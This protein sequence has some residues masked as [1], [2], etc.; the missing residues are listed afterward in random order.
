MRLAAGHGADQ[1]RRPGLGGGY[2]AW[3]TKSLILEFGCIKLC[4]RQRGTGCASL[5]VVG[6]NDQAT[7]GRDK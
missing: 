5:C 7:Q 2:L 3:R 1:P 4:G 6:R